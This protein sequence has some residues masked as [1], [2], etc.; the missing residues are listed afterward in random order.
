MKLHFV[1]SPLALPLALALASLS[2]SSACAVPESEPLG[3]ISAAD[4]TSYDTTVTFA[5]AR[6]G[7]VEPSTTAVITAG[8]TL[9][10]NYDAL[11]LVALSPRCAY[12]PDSRDGQPRTSIDMGVQIN[13]DPK[14]VY[15]FER[16]SLY[17]AE[18]LPRDAQPNNHIALPED[19]RA[20]ELWFSCKSRDGFRGYDSKSGANYRFAVAA[21][22]VPM[23]R[24]D[25]APKTVQTG[26]RNA[27]D[28]ARW[29]DNA[30]F[31]GRDDS[32][33]YPTHVEIAYDD[34]DGFGGNA[35]T[36]A[37][38]V[39]LHTVKTGHGRY[40]VQPTQW[41]EVTLTRVGRRYIG[42]VDT[43]LWGTGGITDHRVKKV[44]LAITNGFDWDSDF[45]KNYTVAY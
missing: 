1:A 29:Y 41:F 12:E 2:L 10:V 19:A 30:V 34:L 32:Y 24:F 20:I 31:P 6:T 16:V 17:G 13:D 15:T 37:A 45:G 11:R 28:V 18:D 5:Y 21:K 44:E 7:L 38:H 23:T 43:Q 14:R 8:S 9:T 3:E 26:R 22:V 36:I 42:Q 4:T 35:A 33:Y 25:A 27:I 40:L 39:G